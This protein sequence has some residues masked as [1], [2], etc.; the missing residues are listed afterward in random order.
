L[1]A[2]VIP[3]FESSTR[4]ARRE[5]DD[6]KKQTINQ[7]NNQLIKQSFNQPIEQSLNGTHQKCSSL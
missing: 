2:A 7:S 4:H 5:T 3:V 1:N 6:L